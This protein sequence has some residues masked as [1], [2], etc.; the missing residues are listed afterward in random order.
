[1]AIDLT[2]K[3]KLQMPLWAMILGIVVLIALLFLVA[4]Y[5][6][7][8]LS[9]KSI[10]KNIQA[11]EAETVD[12]VKEIQAKES[13]VMA[14]QQRINDFSALFAKH[15]NIVNVFALLEQNVLPNVWFN[16]FE[17]NSLEDRTLVLEGNTNSF[18]SIQQQVLIFEEQELIRKVVLQDISIGE[19]GGINFILGFTFHSDIFKALTE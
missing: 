9:A 16:D 5:L 13:E 11:I 15:R 3:R 18:A 8:F 10:D 4:S 1:M 7:L 2:P 12:L 17:F 6:F 19:E 14:V